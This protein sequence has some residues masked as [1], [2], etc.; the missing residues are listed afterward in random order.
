MHGPPGHNTRP[1]AR[2]PTSF[3]TMDAGITLQLNEALVLKL[4][5]SLVCLA[6]FLICHLWVCLNQALEDVR[7]T[8]AGKIFMY[9]SLYFAL[10]GTLNLNE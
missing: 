2:L 7:S 10:Y 3:L 6:Y 4:C 9:C 1:H 5:G 8:G